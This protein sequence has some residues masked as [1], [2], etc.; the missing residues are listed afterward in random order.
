M[1][2]RT[3]KAGKNSRMLSGLLWCGYCG[4]PYH[5]MMD[6]SPL[7]AGKKKYRRYR[8]GANMAECTLPRKPNIR[9]NILDELVWDV[10]IEWL[11]NPGDV[12]HQ[13]EEEL[14]N[15]SDGGLT[16]NLSRLESQ[17]KEHEQRKDSL[18]G[19]LVS[20]LLTEDEARQRIQKERDHISEI[21]AEIDRVRT[22]LS[23]AAAAR[24]HINNT[25]AL[26]LM[27][28]EEAELAD[29]LTRREIVNTLV[30]RVEV[31]YDT[32]GRQ[33]GGEVSVKVEGYF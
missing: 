27:L 12:I 16:R 1:N 28:Q 25:E 15:E 26:L 8:H 32:R 9:T 24:D 13:L 31:F 21:E 29:A 23:N 5:G 30:E 22:L 3:P 20:K 6:S 19:W 18:I 10:I 4:V 11:H 17:L 14:I 33:R 2:N 7:K